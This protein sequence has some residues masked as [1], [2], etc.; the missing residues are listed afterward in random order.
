[1]TPKR[2]D[3]P[4][5]LTQ[6]QLYALMLAIYEYRKNNP[7]DLF[8]TELLESADDIITTEHWARFKEQ[9]RIDDILEQIA[10]DYE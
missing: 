4:I 6:N 3:E 7:T 10:K 1:M 8:V 2:K 5:M 9:Q